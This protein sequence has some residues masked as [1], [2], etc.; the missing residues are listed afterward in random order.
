MADIVENVLQEAA[1]KEAKYKTT[2]VHK[3][4]DLDIDEGN[5]MTS[6]SNPIDLKSFR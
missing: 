4:I 1:A 3:D 2:E 6:D 5:L